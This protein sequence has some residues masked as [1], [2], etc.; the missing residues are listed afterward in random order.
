M[1]VFLSMIVII[2]MYVNTHKNIF[3][4]VPYTNI[5]NK[6][7]CFKNLVEAKQII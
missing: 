6:N 1:Y 4:L 2:N 7:Q 5:K 3:F